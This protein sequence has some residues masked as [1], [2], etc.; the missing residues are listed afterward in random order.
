MVGC[1]V[2]LYHKAMKRQL[3]NLPHL[4]GF[5]LF[6]YQISPKH[7]INQLW[8]RNHVA[9]SENPFKKSEAEGSCTDQFWSH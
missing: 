9:Q 5:F 7:K 6:F 2:G 8:Q 1:I 3:A 4:N